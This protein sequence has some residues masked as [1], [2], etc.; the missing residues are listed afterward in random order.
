MIC[1]INISISLHIKYAAA[2]LLADSYLHS[3]MHTRM[4]SARL[5]AMELQ[6][7]HRHK[8]ETI[9]SHENTNGK[10]LISLVPCMLFK[11]IS[12]NIRD[13]MTIIIIT[14]IQAVTFILI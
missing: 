12:V 11:C 7:L 14:S 8:Q 2:A 6:A 1:L 4:E 10:M 3:M 9:Q 5:S 13:T